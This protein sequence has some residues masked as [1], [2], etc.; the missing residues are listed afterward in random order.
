[1]EA[2]R[3]VIKALLS[4]ERRVQKRSAGDILQL[5]HWNETFGATAL[6][7]Y[8]LIFTRALKSLPATRRF[9]AR[10]GRVRTIRTADGNATASDSEQDEIT[11]HIPP[12][13]ERE[14]YVTAGVKRGVVNELLETWV[15]LDPGPI[16]QITDG[17]RNKDKSRVQDSVSR[18]IRWYI[19]N[20]KT[21]PE[22]ESPQPTRDPS[23]GRSQRREQDGG[24]IRGTN[25]SKEDGS[26][27]MEQ[28]SG[29]PP[30][31][32]PTPPT[33]PKVT[34]SEKTNGVKKD[35]GAGEGAVGAKPD[36]GAQ[37][38]ATPK[39]GSPSRP[40]SPE[41]I[42]L[43]P[44]AHPPTKLEERKKEAPFT[45][46]ASD[47][48]TKKGERSYTIYIAPSA[49]E[50]QGSSTKKSVV[51][52]DDAVVVKRSQSSKRA[53]NEQNSTKEVNFVQDDRRTQHRKD[54]YHS[55]D[56]FASEAR[57]RGRR[58]SLHETDRATHTGVPG[59]AS[60]RNG[61]RHA[62]SRLHPASTMFPDTTNPRSNNSL[63]PF[64]MG[65]HYG[66]TQQIH[67]QAPP[68]SAPSGLGPGRGYHR[69]SMPPVASSGYYPTHAQ[70]NGGPEDGK[71]ARLTELQQR[72]DD[73]DKEE[74]AREQARKDEAEARKEEG[75]R[76]AQEEERRIAAQ[77]QEVEELRRRIQDLQ[78]SG[79]RNEQ[80]WE[81]EKRSIE[82][83]I[84]ETRISEEQA[85][86][87]AE[88]ATETT[89]STNK[90][91][92]RLW[93]FIA[94]LQENERRR[95]DEWAKERD[96]IFEEA[97]DQIQR[98]VEEGEEEKQAAIKGLISEYEE[99][100]KAEQQKVEQA[101]VRAERY[102][103]LYN[104]LVTAGR[105]N[106]GAMSGSTKASERAPDPFAYYDKHQHSSSASSM[107]D[108]SAMETE[109]TEPRTVPWDEQNPWADRSPYERF[110]PQDRTRRYTASVATRS[111]DEASNVIVFPPRAGWSEFGPNQLG[112]YL[113]SSGFK[114]MFEERER[115]SQHATGR[116]EKIGTGGN[117]LRGTLFW[118]PPA[119]TAEADLYKSL[120]N[121]GWRPTYVRTTSKRAS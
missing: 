39:A 86:R 62:S 82:R 85:N 69:N 40:S 36:E 108:G 77:R 83:R 114:A 113:S 88:E 19:E 9:N 33:S 25:R 10:G 29:E 107:Y 58:R 87:R 100:L 21:A 44:P 52:K 76:R 117:V 46:T 93:E 97:H 56:G 47:S 105:E 81:E 22:E 42:V 45:V 5:R 18:I 90:T 1:M 79:R 2:S 61:P 68:A 14:L 11:D 12:D 71:N 49:R 84:E 26:R 57:Q 3:Q 65:G 104:G 92:D 54:E 112:N 72:M 103:T 6:W 102:V 106:V 120:R 34:P 48:V 116:F 75:R 4:S 7:V 20:E 55:S 115:P 27:R 16:R 121:C 13:L 35:A 78:E 67:M 32:V 63:N 80:R 43:P 31:K 15:G 109:T 91:E 50:K 101:N 89:Q 110:A 60:S 119:S 17:V 95:T 51:P 73:R 37:A 23:R 98:A 99:K 28:T 59:D 118:Q 94:S 53:P 24:D 111:S 38:T 96:S 66:P 41:T 8:N 64:G 30:P 70:Q 74:R